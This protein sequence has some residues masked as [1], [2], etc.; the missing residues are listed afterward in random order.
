MCTCSLTSLC[1]VCNQAMFDVIVSER[2]I[3]LFSVTLLALKIQLTGMNCLFH[4]HRACRCHWTQ[5]H[6]VLSF[7]VSF[8]PFHVDFSFRFCL[9]LSRFASLCLLYHCANV[10]L[11]LLNLSLCFPHTS[12][13]MGQSPCITPILPLAW[14]RKGS[15]S[16][17][18]PL[19]KL[20]GAIKQP[21]G[22]V[23]SQMVAAE[24]S[25]C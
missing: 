25:F 17:T 8:F 18:F 9:T 1:A 16:A 14:L 15:N 13:S 4:K 2:I 6:F 3:L 21:W 23:G 20:G 24:L 22:L 7:I 10:S 19:V 12:P 11:F 5:A